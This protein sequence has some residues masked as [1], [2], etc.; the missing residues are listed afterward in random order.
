MGRVTHGVDRSAREMALESLSPQCP[1]Q[2]PGIDP[3]DATP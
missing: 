3:L 1:Q 2:L